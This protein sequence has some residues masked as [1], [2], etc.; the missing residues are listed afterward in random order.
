MSGGPDSTAL[1]ALAAAAGCVVEA[2]HVDHGMRPGSADE[3][4]VVARTAARLGCDFRAVRVEVDDGPNLEARLRDAR[5]AV[6]P[7]DVMTGHTAD[8]QVETMLLNLLRGAGRS[9]LSAMR[10]GVRRPILGLRRAE[11]VG[12]C[13]ALGL[14]TL[15]DP[16]NLDPRH[17]RNRI[18]H[19]L[20][21]MM[22]D[23]AGRDLV[24]VLTRQADLLRDEHDLLDVLAAEIDPTD[25][26]ALAGAPAALARRAVRRWIGGTHPPDLATVERVLAVARGEAT[27]TDIGGRRRVS[28]S[29]QR[30]RID[31]RPQAPDGNG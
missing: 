22:V 17:L 10:P 13:D 11:T 24:P 19:E 2:I 31:E 29:H 5:Y 7:A 15:D 3:A 26:I 23:L 14:E 6:L 16:T 28:R 27:G 21:P 4:L 20:L 9:G 25:A 1:V 18:R 8:D 12:L 30:L